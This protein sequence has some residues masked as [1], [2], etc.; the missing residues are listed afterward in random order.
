MH[1]PLTD[2]RRELVLDLLTPL[3]G[4]RPAILR[5][6]HLGHPWAAVTRLELDVVVPFM[7]SCVVVKTWRV[8]GDG[9]GGPAFLLREEGG[10]RIA[11]AA[12]VGPA[13]VAVNQQ[14]GVLVLE[15]LEGPTVE[16]VRLGDDPDAAMA[17]M[18]Q[19]GGA[20]GRL[21]GATFTVVDA[22][23]RRRPWAGWSVGTW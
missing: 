5:Q 6:D 14:A 2:A 3:V 17:A 16:S 23:Q 11:A 20:V 15:C 21:H 13:V 18:V 4:S 8:D 22:A 9:Y 7:G 10:A 1:H 12:G 19:L